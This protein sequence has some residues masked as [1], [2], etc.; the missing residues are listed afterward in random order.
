MISSFDT[1]LPVS[2]STFAYLI[3]WPVFFESRY[4]HGVERRSTAETAPVIVVV[5]LIHLVIGNFAFS[6][7]ADRNSPPIGLVTEC[8]GGRLQYIDCC[9]PAAR[10][11]VLF[12]AID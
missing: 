4:R 1:S 5:A 8:D 7:L 3:R 6:V 12:H 9:D 11:V 10:C 2:A